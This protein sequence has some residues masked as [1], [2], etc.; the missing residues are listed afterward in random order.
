VVQLGLKV[1]TTLVF[2]LSLSSITAFAE[3][4]QYRGIKGW[5]TKGC[6]H[7]ND[8]FSCVRYVKNYDGDTVTFD[9]PSVHPLI[10]DEI[11]VRVKGI[12]TPEKR[13]RNDCEKR[14]AEIA[15][16][17]VESMMT[18][19]KRIDLINTERGKYFRVIA[20]IFI[21][22]QSLADHLL[23]K[24]LAVRYQGGTKPDIDWCG[25]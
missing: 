6:G 19:A 12:D 10:G 2:C 17:E 11:M 20:D 3:D 8:G 23:K 4:A 7:E 25:E 21:D 15:Q 5:S 24:K 22:G 13:T 14:M 18:N 1:F 9:I 16:K